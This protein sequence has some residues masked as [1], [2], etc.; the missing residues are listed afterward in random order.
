[1]LLYM[2][3]LPRNFVVYDKVLLYI[4]GIFNL[5]KLIFYDI[6]PLFFTQQTRDI[7]VWTQFC[8]LS[9]RRLV[10]EWDEKQ[11]RY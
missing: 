10:V 2:Q 3:S 6:K 7:Y 5:N 9:T 4:K 8:Y 11:L 1:M